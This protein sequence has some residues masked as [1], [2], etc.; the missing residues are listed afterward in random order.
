M[1]TPV[2]V[3]IFHGIGSQGPNFADPMIRNLTRRVESMLPPTSPPPVVF[4][5][6][7]WGDALCQGEQALCSPRRIPPYLGWQR[8]RRQ[9]VTWLGDAIAYEPTMRSRASYDAVHGCVAS[10][11]GELSRS[12]G[13]EAPL[14]VIA[15]SFGSVIANNYFHDL[16]CL[17][18]TFVPSAVAMEVSEDVRQLAAKASLAAGQTLA[19][20]ITLG[21]PLGV[22][23]LRC[24]EA[25]EPLSIPGRLV[26]QRYPH[27]DGLWLN[28]L[29]LSDILASPLGALSPAYGRLVI[30]IPVRLQGFLTGWNPL[31]H[32]RYWDDATVLQSIAAALAGLWRDAN[33]VEYGTSDDRAVSDDLFLR[34]STY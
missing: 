20:M 21:S 15:H 27:V 19:M 32:F 17:D 1:T 23:S 7:H 6:I 34:R 3:A 11:L 12:A 14:C 28:F 16:Q 30:D 8:S 31:S 4:R 33:G 22:L 29:G 13:G 2:A 10:Q 9:V 25:A 24:P 18:G 5:A 26:K